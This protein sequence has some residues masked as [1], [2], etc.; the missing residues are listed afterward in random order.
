MSEEGEE[1]SG[2]AP[3]IDPEAVARAEPIVESMRGRFLD[4]LGKSQAAIA[5][6]QTMLNSKTG[7]HAALL[8]EIKGVAHEMKGMGGTFGYPLV[9]RVG[10]TLEHYLIEAEVAGDADL[11]IVQD[12]ISAIGEMMLAF[13]VDL[14]GDTEARLNKLADQLESRVG[15]D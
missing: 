5:E 10:R 6:K 12:H 2:V 13:K 4:W 7:N 1:N 9:T 3:G 14:D 11:S 15:A 8:A